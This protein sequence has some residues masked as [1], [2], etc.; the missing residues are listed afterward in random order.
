LLDNVRLNQARKTGAERFF[1]CGR[2]FWE[3]DGAAYEL[4]AVTF[5]VLN[6]ERKRS[7]LSREKTDYFRAKNHIEV[8]ARMAGFDLS[9]EEYLPVSGSHSTWQEG[10][11]ATVGGLE[12][13]FEA[14]MG[15]L[16]P[17]LLKAFDIEGS[18]VAGV[19]AFLPDRLLEIDRPVRMRPVSHFPAAERDLALVVPE[20]VPAG[21]VRRRL[22]GIAREAAGSLFVVESVESFDL[23]RGQGLPAASKSLAF[24][25]TFR[26]DDRT[27]TDQE[28][29]GVFQA[30]QRRILEETEFTIRQ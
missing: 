28:V 15:L 23:Y 20:E 3:H 1:E 24:S 25:L 6:D 26:A 27:L 7:W 10:H 5:I 29:N 8:L 17:F 2:I 30:I 22:L 12:K 4:N 9:E 14:R 11:S 13:G 21:T 18:A 19:F 16:S